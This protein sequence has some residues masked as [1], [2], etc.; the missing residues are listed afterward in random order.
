MTERI[1]RSGAS[2][3]SPCCRRNRSDNLPFRPQ[4]TNALTSQAQPDAVEGATE[5]CGG[6]SSAS[7][8]WANNE[9]SPKKATNPRGWVAYPKITTYYS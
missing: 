6:A 8:G 1:R 2:A 9:H 3:V 4:P 5:K 7:G